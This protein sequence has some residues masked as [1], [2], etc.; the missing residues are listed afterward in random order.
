MH[1]SIFSSKSSIYVNRKGKNIKIKS[2]NERSLKQRST[3]ISKDRPRTSL[4]SSS[5]SST[6]PWKLLDRKGTRGVSSASSSSFSSGYVASRC[7]VNEEEEEEEEEDEKDEDEDEEEDEKEKE[8][9]DED[10][11]EEEE[12]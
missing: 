11:E 4:S 1:K 6:A 9:K 2:W 12:E 3:R 10:E 7:V 8:E 5:K